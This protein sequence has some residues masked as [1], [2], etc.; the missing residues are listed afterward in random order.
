MKTKQTTTT[1]KTTKQTIIKA[2]QDYID[3][4]QRD[5]DIFNRLVTV[6]K[7]FENKPINKRLET[8]AKL[9]FP[10]SV[11][12]LKHEF[13]MYN[14]I[15]W[16]QKTGYD[17]RVTLFMGYDRNP[18]YHEGQADKEHSGFRY[19]STCC[20]AAAIAR[21]NT[22]KKLLNDPAEINNLVKIYD[23][24]IRYKNIFDNMSSFELPAFY[25]INRALGLLKD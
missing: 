11:V 6:F 21:I 22:C 20:G 19:Y 24:Y 15:I 16:D 13:G 2:I 7:K 5:N 4:E 25:N 3:H 9:E 10:E 23:N 17:N 12:N 8:A 18:I 14:L 1:A